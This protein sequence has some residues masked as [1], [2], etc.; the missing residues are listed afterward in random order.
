MTVCCKHDEKS[1]EGPFPPPPKDFEDVE[2]AKKSNGTDY[3]QDPSS[4]GH[5]DYDGDYYYDY[6]YEISCLDD[7]G[8]PRKVGV[9]TSLDFQAKQSKANG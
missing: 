1:S 8:E 5:F 2:V 4:Y 3:S 9:C 6:T 7:N